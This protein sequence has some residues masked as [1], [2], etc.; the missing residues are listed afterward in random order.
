MRKILLAVDNSNIYVPTKEIFGHDARFS[1]ANFEKKT[2]SLDTFV[3][4][5]LTGSTPPS[6]DAFWSRME[7]NGYEV[8]T[9]EQKQVFSEGRLRKKEKSADTDLC[10]RATEAIIDHK[11]DVLVLCS[12]DLDMLPLV[13]MA[14]K[15]SCVVHLWT[16]RKSSASDLEK[17]CDKVF[18]I[19]DDE[20]EDLFLR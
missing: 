2:Y 12:G 3:V 7:Q 5:L 1:Y 19:D 11:P 15:Y 20:N 18:Y 16:F 17:E 10:V 6:N 9:Y 14:K 8:V 4:K 13:K